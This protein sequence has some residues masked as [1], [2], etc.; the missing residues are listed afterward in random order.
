MNASLTPPLRPAGALAGSA[1]LLTVDLGALARNY[2]ALR[3]RA[4]GAS[5]AGVVKADAYGLGAERVARRLFEAGC[6]TFFVAHLCEAL[7]LRPVLDAQ[8]ELFVLN[9]LAPGDERLCAENAILPVLNSLPQVEAWAAL[10]RQSSRALPAAIQVDS[11]MSRLGLSPGEVE[12]LRADPSRLS[13]VETVLVMSHLACADEPAHPANRQ[14]L[15]AFRSLSALLPEARRSLA[16]SAGIFLGADFRF[17]LVRPGIAVYGGAPVGG[18]PNPMEPV[19]RLRARV[20]QLREVKAGAGIGYGFSRVAD[21]PMRLATLSV[22]YADG[23]LRSAG[24]RGVAAFRGH[25]LPIAGR[26]S[27]D[28]IIVDA[29]DAPLEAGDL[30][31]LIG[32]DASLD[33]AAA[34]AGTISYEILTSLGHRFERRFIDTAEQ[35]ER[36]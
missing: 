22:G 1:G 21:G 7:A 27:M 23:W 30:V 10:G 6:R 34:A 13:G 14:Q 28:S 32:P 15:E 18:V 29:G 4:G 24:N 19:V 20:V 2:E 33:A 17:D 3:A 5:V 25:Q 35:G 16:N 9:G 8:A 36:A 26:V 31:D 11:G 12:A